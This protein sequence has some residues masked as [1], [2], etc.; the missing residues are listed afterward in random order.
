MF[1]L[2]AKAKHVL[3]PAETTSTSSHVNYRYLSTPQKVQRLRQLSQKNRQLREKIRRLQRKLDKV[4]ETSSV[5]LDDETSQDL[6]D[7]MDQQDSS[8]QAKYQEDSFEAIFWRHQKHSLSKK[9]KDKNGNRW[10]PLMIRWCLYL[11]HCSSKA[12]EVIRESGCIA[13][14]SQRTLRDYSN[15]VKA[16]AGFS[17]E[18]DEQLLQASKLMTSASYHALVFILLDEMHIREEL[19]FDKHTGKLIGFVDLGS[20][21]NHLSQFEQLLST[22]DDC[23]NDGKSDDTDNEIPLAKSMMVFMVRGIFTTLRFPYALF[24]CCSL[25]GEQLFSP[26][27]ECVFRLERIGFKVYHV[28]LYNDITFLIHHVH[29]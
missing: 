20:V 23:G 27:W 11:R 24:P 22:E 6:Q 17:S 25:V 26:F 16:G 7:I 15:A 9:G 19:V 28:Y 5:L 12:Y 3:S 1:A 10:H 14:P 13:L 4:Y 29:V 18:L 21:N 2:V 8:V